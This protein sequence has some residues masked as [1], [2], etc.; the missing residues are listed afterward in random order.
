MSVCM[1]VYTGTVRRN[2]SVDTDVNMPVCRTHTRAH[3]HT[4]THTHTHRYVVDTSASLFCSHTLTHAHMHACTHTHTVTHAHT[5]LHAH[6]Q[7][8]WHT[9]TCQCA[10]V[11]THAWRTHT[12]FRWRPRMP[13]GV[14]VYITNTGKKMCHVILVIFSTHLVAV[15]CEVFTKYC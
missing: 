10:C 4:H 5:Q 8:H 6:T 12:P 9:H 15:K 3:T 13:M 7:S 14:K 2:D 11:R 1:F